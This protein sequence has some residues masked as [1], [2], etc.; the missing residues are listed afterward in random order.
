MPFQVAQPEQLSDIRLESRLINLLENIV[1]NVV[2]I[3]LKQM[4]MINHLFGICFRIGIG[5]DNDE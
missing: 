4:L 2:R 1:V 5:G 3:L